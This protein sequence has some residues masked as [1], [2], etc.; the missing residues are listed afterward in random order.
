MN[1]S[2]R[3]TAILASV[4]PCAAT[5]AFEND[6]LVVGLED[7]RSVSVPLE[8]FPSLRDAT[9]AQRNNWELI[10]GGIGIHWEDLDEDLSVNGLLNPNNHVQQAV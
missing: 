5:V 4:P 7:G 9:E 8:W 2:K 3:G 10:G 1:S 6:C